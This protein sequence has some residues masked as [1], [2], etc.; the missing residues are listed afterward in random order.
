MGNKKE[1][2]N[3]IR[4]GASEHKRSDL[5]YSYNQASKAFNNELKNENWENA[6]L[7]IEKLKIRDV[8]KS[9]KKEE[10]IRRE[11]S[12]FKKLNLVKNSK[13]IEPTKLAIEFSNADKNL[14]ENYFFNINKMEYDFLQIFLFDDINGQK[15]GFKILKNLLENKNIYYEYNDN[16]KKLVNDKNYSKIEKIIKKDVY[17]NSGSPNNKTYNLGGKIFTR[18]SDKKNYLIDKWFDLSLKKINENILEKKLIIDFLLEFKELSNVYNY[19][20]SEF[21]EETI[22]PLLIDESIKKVNKNKI[23]NDIN[24][25]KYNESLFPKTFDEL[26]KRSINRIIKGSINSYKCLVDNHIRFIPY[27][28]DSKNKFFVKDNYKLLIQSIINHQNELE[29]EFLKN[30]YINRERFKEIIKIKSQKI[31]NQ[32]EEI[33][34]LYKSEYKE[35]DKVINILNLYNFENDSNVKKARIK[36]DE[37]INKSNHIKGRCNASTYFE[38]IIGLSLLIKETSIFKMKPRNFVE[39][40]KKSLNL[41]FSSDKLIPY[42]HAPGGRPD[43]N[44]EKENGD[45]IAEPT[46]QLKDQTKMEADSIRRHINS[47]NRNIKEVFFVSPTIEETVRVVFRAWKEKNLI[48]HN[49]SCLTT[50]D[51]IEYLKK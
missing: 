40:I 20:S 21:G 19:K 47:Y 13:K 15:Q 3:L 12:M 41:K 27:I 22:I 34:E 39:T 50:K 36:I 37:H 26:L 18:M 42:I 24:N 35:I 48:K 16:V 31:N 8:F 25:C 17:V 6:S 9:N 14:E 2:V 30:G 5:M 44:I 45:I 49:V 51:L 32:N 46:I 7:I 1:I 23:I 38:F 29:E 4:P 11:Y 33:M 10:K 28:D 43:V